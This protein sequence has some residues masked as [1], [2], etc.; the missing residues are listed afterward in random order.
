VSVLSLLDVKAALFALGYYDGKIDKT[1]DG[2]YRDDLRRY[3]RDH[4][5]VPDGAY[6]AKSDA[7]LQPQWALICAL[8]DAGKLPVSVSMRRWQLTYYYIGQQASFSGPRTIP[9]R[10]PQGS[11]IANLEP[12]AFVQAALEGTSVLRDG[13]LVNVGGN[14]K[15]LAAPAATLQPLYDIAK[16]SNWLPDKPGYAGIQL[17]ADG[18]SARAARTFVQIKPGTGGW[19]IWNRIEARPFLT[20]AADLGNQPRHDPS[21]KGKGG[22]V[23][24]GTNAL[25]LELSGIEIPGPGQDEPH[26]GWCTVN[27]TG[28]GIF[29]AH[30]DVFTGT[31]ALADEVAIPHRAHVWFEG[32]EKKLPMSYSYGL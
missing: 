28:G 6:G 29:G 20:L 12:R 27:D 9:M 26:D 14:P 22:V 7:K 21:W 24:V 5:L 17:A 23:P 8:I 13:R 2:N 1:L 11:L 18:K 10:T 3:Q 31:R 30:F 15:Y 32:I 4:G 16:R 19:P 25:V